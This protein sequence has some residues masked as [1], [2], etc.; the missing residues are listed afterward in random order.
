MFV[1]IKLMKHVLILSVL[2]WKFSNKLLLLSVEQKILKL[3]C[4]R[5]K[6]I[7]KVWNLTEV[8]MLVADASEIGKTL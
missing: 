2:N 5:Q 4:G 7:L 1:F 8:E 3:R 6:A